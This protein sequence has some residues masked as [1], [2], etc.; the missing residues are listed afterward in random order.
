MGTLQ[1]RNAIPKKSLCLFL[2]METFKLTLLT[3][4]QKT[5][6]ISHKSIQLSF[7]N[8]FVAANEILCR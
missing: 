5:D 7:P 1:K 2:P 3:S 4:S 8:T 6:Y